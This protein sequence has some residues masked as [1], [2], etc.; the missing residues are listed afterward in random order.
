MENNN[1]LIVNKILNYC[2]DIN[3]TVERFGDSLEVFTKDKDFQKSICFSIAQIGELTTRFSDDY[4][5]NTQKDVDWRGAKGL[6]N[7]VVH[8]YGAISFEVIWDIVKNEIPEIQLFC[9]QQLFS[10]QLDKTEARR[11]NPVSFDLD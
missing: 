10:S 3:E 9:E 11:N 1:N 4:K 2:Q 7:I 8:N 5:M 6:R